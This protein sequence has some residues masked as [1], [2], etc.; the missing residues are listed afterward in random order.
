[1]KLAKNSSAKVFLKL[2]A[3]LALLAGVSSMSQ[4]CFLA[5]NQPKVPEGM[6]KFRSEKK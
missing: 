3:A 4:T 5:F 6:D 1:M 2:F